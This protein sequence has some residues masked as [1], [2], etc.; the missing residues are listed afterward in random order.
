MGSVGGPSY[1]AAK[2]AV[3]AMSHSIN[4][5]ECVNG[6][7]ST[8]LCPGEVA[9]PLLDQRPV[10]VTPQEREQMLQ[11]EDLGDLLAYLAR[12]PARVCINEVLLSPTWRIGTLEAEY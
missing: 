1:T 5:E 10:P 12:L 2:H 7:R 6:I 11:P 8:V 9:T 3:V 4:A